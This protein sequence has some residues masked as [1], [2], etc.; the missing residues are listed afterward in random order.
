M[1]TLPDSVIPNGASAQVVTFGGVL[2][3]PLGG[4][5]L[6]LNRLG[7]RFL[8]NV[9]LPPLPAATGREVVSLL[10]QGVREGLR[11]PYPLLDV[12]QSGSGTPLV[13]GAGQSGLTINLDGLTPS[14]QVKRGYWISIVDAAGQHYLHVV[15][16]D[17]SAN[18][19]GVIALPIE[20]MLRVP[21]P[22][23]AVVNITK[24]MIEGL[25]V[26]NELQWQLAIER[27]IGISFGI[28]EAA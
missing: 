25:V 12:D 4:K 3:P 19:S 26:G 21:F 6:K 18:G 5:L 1:I 16:N 20:T 11:M 17:T 2:R 22:D 13:N 14:Y 27:N 7:D 8:I 24:P 23:N 28:E 9:T 15:R 10:L